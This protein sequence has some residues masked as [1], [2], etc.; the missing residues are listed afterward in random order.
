MG[1]ASALNEIGL[2][3]GKFYTSII[4][5]NGGVELG[6]ILIIV[7]IFSSIVALWGEKTLVSPTRRLSSVRPYCSYR[8]LLDG[9]T[10]VF[11]MR[12]WNGGGGENNNEG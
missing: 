12:K 11:S 1:F 4:A 6:Q 5:F 7:T 8:R 9:D 10:V 2:P 3:P